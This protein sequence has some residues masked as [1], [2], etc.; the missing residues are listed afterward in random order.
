MAQ[1]SSDD[2]GSGSNDDDGD[3]QNGP[4]EYIQH[5]GEFVLVC[6]VL[7]ERLVALRTD[8]QRDSSWEAAAAAAATITAL[9]LL[10]TTTTISRVKQ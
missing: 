7:V 3:W 6:C 5:G 10:E 2:C 8:R 1:R 9:I 4:E